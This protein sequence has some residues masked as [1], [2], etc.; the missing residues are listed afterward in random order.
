[1]HEHKISPY[2]AATFKRKWM[3]ET[4]GDVTVTPAIADGV[5]YFTTWVGEVFAVSEEHGRVLWRKNLTQEFDSPKLLQSRNTPVVHKRYLLLGI[6]VPALQIALD[7]HTGNLLWSKV[8][9]S[10]PYAGISM[11]GT[12][13]D[14]YNKSLNSI[15]I[16][17]LASRSCYN[18]VVY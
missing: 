11:S 15:H 14:R 4:A 18:C 3:V 8:L 13:F 5:V 12:V 9:D 16:I 1:M 10:H 7:R 2:S 17:S 6:L